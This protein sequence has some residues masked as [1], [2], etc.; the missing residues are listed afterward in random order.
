MMRSTV[1]AA[2]VVQSTEHQV[3]GFG[4]GQRQADGL[5]VAQFADQDHVRILAQCRTQRRG[6]AARIAVKLALIDEAALAA[7]HEFHRVLDGQH[8]LVV[9]FVDV[10]DHRRQGRALA[11]AGRPRHQ[12]QSSRQGGQTAKYL[13][14]FQV[15]EVSTSLGMV[16]KTAPAP[17]P[18]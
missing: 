12:H 13:A 1:L 9:V 17:R 6:E 7:V 11:R 4:G 3:A 15:V 16:R 14:Q 10:V 18:W 5:Q 2:D 8:M